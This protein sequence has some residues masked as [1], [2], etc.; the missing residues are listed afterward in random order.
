MGAAIHAL[1][2]HGIHL[3]ADFL[4]GITDLHAEFIA[5]HCGIFLHTADT[6]GNIRTTPLEGSDHFGAGH[7]ILV[8]RVIDKLRESGA[9]RSIQADDAKLQ[10]FGL[11]MEAEHGGKQQGEDGFHGR[12]YLV[13]G[14]D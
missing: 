10:I 5:Q 9:V 2:H 1:D 6:G 12:S 8:C 3:T 14:W 11:A 7:V 13:M 4:D